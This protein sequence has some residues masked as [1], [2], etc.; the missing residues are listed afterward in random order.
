ML[1]PSR[2]RRGGDPV[3]ERRVQLERVATK[4]RDLI[5]VMRPLSLQ[6]GGNWLRE[7]MPRIENALDKVEAEHAQI[8]L[9]LLTACSHPWSHPVQAIEGPRASYG[10][11]AACCEA[12]LEEARGEELH[13]L[14]SV[15][16]RVSQAHRLSETARRRRQERRGQGCPRVTN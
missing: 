15:H 12:R 3:Q 14:R 2:Q 16:E 6:P 10:R 13:R 4:I 5:A 9:D 1:T 11:V 8:D 7:A